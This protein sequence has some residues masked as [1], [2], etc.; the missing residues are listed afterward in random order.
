MTNKTYNGQPY[1]SKLRLGVPNCPTRCSQ[2]HMYH[3]VA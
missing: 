3:L 1:S 2:E